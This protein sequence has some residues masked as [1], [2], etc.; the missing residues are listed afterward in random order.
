MTAKKA[1]R[2]RRTTPAAEAASAETSA[3]DPE[4]EQFNNPSNRPD[5]TQDPRMQ[6]AYNIVRAQFPNLPQPHPLFQ[7]R[8]RAE[9]YRLRLWLV[10]GDTLRFTP[11]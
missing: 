3:A 4:V 6:T 5:P 1:A 9:C 2:R 11:S 7:K 8:F 10:H